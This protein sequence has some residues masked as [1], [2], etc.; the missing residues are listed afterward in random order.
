MA[1]NC[2][3]RDH[4]ATKRVFS[5]VSNHASPACNCVKTA[6]VAEAGHHR[7]EALQGQGH[8]LPV[9]RVDRGVDEL[10]QRRRGLAAFEPSP[11]DGKNVVEV[12]P[13]PRLLRAL[14]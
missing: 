5:T 11:L 9:Q 2:V 8:L 10:Q 4:Y 3:C 13:E 7:L 1:Q 6:W 14:L 12:V